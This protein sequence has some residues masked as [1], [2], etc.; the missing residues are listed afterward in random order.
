MFHGLGGI[1]LI[2]WLGLFAVRSKVVMATTLEALSEA[3]CGSLMCRDVIFSSLG[4]KGWGRFARRRLGPCKK[5]VVVDQDV[6]SAVKVCR[7]LVYSHGVVIIEVALEDGIFCWLRISNGN[8]GNPLIHGF[9]AELFFGGCI[10]LFVSW[11]GLDK[12]I[13]YVVAYKRDKNVCF[14]FKSLLEIGWMFILILP[15]EEEAE[16]N[17]CQLEEWI[18]GPGWIVHD[19]LDHFEK[20]KGV[21]FNFGFKIRVGLNLSGHVRGTK[22]LHDHR[23]C[24]GLVL[25]QI[26]FPG[27]IFFYLSLGDHI[28]HLLFCFTLVV[29]LLG[30]DLGLGHFIGEINKLFISEG[31]GDVMSI[32]KIALDVEEGLFFDF[33]VGSISL[34][35]LSWL[36]G[37]ELHGWFLDGLIFGRVVVVGLLVEALTEGLSSAD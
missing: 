5:F 25:A 9:L 37:M 32:F 21:V 27:K 11:G 17:V 18:A 7:E 28:K 34:G 1:P 26:V 29:V 19:G 10:G 15:T 14:L 36:E 16:G 23:E 31:F 6:Y 2:G 33:G 30:G 3:G 4:F 24:L 22:I 35:R 13:K 20:L 12:F 8:E